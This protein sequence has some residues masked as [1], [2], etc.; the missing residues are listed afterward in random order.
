V[1]DFAE[2]KEGEEGEEGRGRRGISI[3]SGT[4]GVEVELGLNAYGD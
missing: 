1:I 2:R 4:D 3:G